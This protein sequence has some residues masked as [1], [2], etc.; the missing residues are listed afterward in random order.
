[1]KNLIVPVFFLATSTLYAQ[2]QLFVAP[3]GNNANPGTLARPLASLEKA[4]TKVKSSPSDKVQIFLRKGIY[5]LPKTVR[6]DPQITQGKS[7]TIS[8]YQTETAQ[9]SGG[10]R[11]QLRWKK[12]PNGIWTAV[13]TGP[14]FEQLLVNGQKQVLARYP[15]YDA[16]ARVYNGTAADALSDERIRRWK[17]PKGGYV[18]ALHKGEWG[19][20]HYRIT[21]KEAGQ[22]KLEG[23]WQNNRPAPMH[24][25]ER[26]VENIAE[27]LDAPGEWF[28]N[29]TTHVLSLMPPP[30]V[31]LTTARIDVSRLKGL[32][33]LKGNPKDPLKN[34]HVHT[35]RFVNAERTFMETNEP[36]LRSDWMIYRGAAVFLEN[37]ENCQFTNC[38]FT[39]L[40]GNALFMSAYNRNSVVKGS[41]FHAIGASAICFVG[42][43]SAVRSPAFRYEEFVP[44]AKQDRLP[45]PKSEAYPAQCVA[46]DNLIHHIGQL[47]KQAAGVEISMA[48]GIV[49]R[50]NSIYQVPRAGINISEGTWGGHLLEYNDVFDT[51]LETGDHGSFNSWGRD[52]FWHPNRAT[53]DSLV[54]AHPELIDLDAKATTIIRNNRF[55]CD[56]GWDID[57]DDGSS[58]YLIT[59]NVCLNGGLK[60]RE[61]FNRVA[62]NNILVNNSF[63]P[64][65]WFKNSGDVFRRNIVMRPYAPIGITEWG[66]EV[67]FNEFPDQAALLKAQKNGTDEHSLAG[68][69]QFMN[70][71]KGDYRVM[72][73]S[74]ALKIG[75]QNFGM[76]QFGVQ[77]P[78]LRFIAETPKL[79]VLLNAQLEDTVK[80]MV[81]LGATIRN[82]QGL[83]DRSAF[84]LP[85]EKGVIVVNIPTESLLAASG[86]QKGDVIRTANNE[87]VPTIGRLIAIQQQI[88]WTGRL[89]VT[90]MRNQQ[91]LGLTLP[92]K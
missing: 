53:M 59:N 12:N 29:R 79:P 75:F 27:E 55:R 71:A 5:Y 92:L 20:F 23:G 1:M 76:N 61:G 43:S 18:H 38:E 88:N 26:F 49:V 42:D 47:E 25:Q 82:V 58:N 6:I 44:Y 83:G 64:H 81:W 3:S 37:T 9:L 7:L 8:N 41:Y 60:F 14:A 91:A 67:D 65:V 19:D 11:L 66:K 57:L 28:Y 31:N 2:T 74:P 62:E 68:D 77:R 70:A 35:I 45:G 87:E 30:G 15:N 85:D 54:A 73:D 80:E 17:A 34:V 36:L 51:V 52:R 22:V 50:H 90:I 84:G 89:P 32:L 24:P 56:H 40:G 46:E 33:E 48:S 4:L 21:G 63:H 69:S 10:R 39:E 86:L 72:P 78:A 16:K 13:V